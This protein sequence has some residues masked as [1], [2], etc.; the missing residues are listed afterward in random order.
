MFKVFTNLGTRSFHFASGLVF[1][2]SGELLFLRYL[3]R[4]GLGLEIG[5]RFTTDYDLFLPFFCALFLTLFSLHQRDV[6][7]F[8]FSKKNLA[9]HS[10]FLALFVLVSWGASGLW[11][12]AG[13][14]V[15]ASFFSSFFSLR[16]LFSRPVLELAIPFLLVAFS[17]TLVLNLPNFLW[18]A[19]LARTG[20]WACSVLTVL[21][22]KS[23][24]VVEGTLGANQES[25]LNL[26]TSFM[27]FKIGKGCAGLEGIFLFSSI[28]MAWLGISPKDPGGVVTSVLFVSG[29]FYI[30]FLNV[31]RLFLVLGAVR[32]I[33][34]VWGIEAAYRWGIVI[35]H[36]HIGWLVYLA[37]ILLF[38]HT[39][40][41]L[42]EVEW[43]FKSVLRTRYT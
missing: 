14:L 4:Q 11:S 7:R 39:A 15:V 8:H 13:F 30:L 34:Q 20:N 23:Q 25:V 21:V 6:L 17:I 3:L 12:L 28:F 26:S 9:V 38:F 19:F 43:K 10:L 16:A 37:G 1:L 5:W 18:N 41:C 31:L 29:L 33:F 27:A 22:P 24:C 32:G 40:S 2:L 36:T 42:Q 35:F